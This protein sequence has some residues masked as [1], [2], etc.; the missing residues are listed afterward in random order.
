MQWEKSRQSNQFAI[1]GI[2][3]GMGRKNNNLDTE[4]DGSMMQHKDKAKL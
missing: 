3:N 2:G 1:Q 4:E